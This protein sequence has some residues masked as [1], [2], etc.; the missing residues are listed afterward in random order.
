MQEISSPHFT[1]H[2]RRKEQI[3]SGKCGKKNHK[4]VRNM[5]EYKSL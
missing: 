4:E 2:P 5:E 1:R 3:E